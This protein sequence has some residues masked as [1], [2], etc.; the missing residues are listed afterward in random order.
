V[1]DMEL[2]QPDRIPVVAISMLRTNFDVWRVYA[3]MT[4]EAS[5]CQIKNSG[6]CDYCSICLTCCDCC[7]SPIACH[8]ERSEE[9]AAFVRQ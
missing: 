6:F 4:Q 2:P 1:V 9:S 7:K 3:K 8:S 5:I